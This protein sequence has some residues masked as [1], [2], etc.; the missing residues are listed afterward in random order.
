ME[1]QT[2]SNRSCIETKGKEIKMLVGKWRRRNVDQRV[3]SY[4]LHT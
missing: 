4:K 2:N 1:L 3:T